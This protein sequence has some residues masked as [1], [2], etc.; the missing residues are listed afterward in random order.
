M[1]GK[2]RPR[3]RVAVVDRA[4]DLLERCQRASVDAPWGPELLPCTS[5][6]EVMGGARQDSLDGV[7]VR[8]PDAGP[9]LADLLRWADQ[10]LEPVLLYVEGGLEQAPE[11][12]RLALS[13]PFVRWRADA[14]ARLDGWL[15]DVA[16]LEATNRYRRLHEATAAELRGARMQLYHG[17]AEAAEPVAGPPCGPPL[18]TALAEVVPLKAAKMRFEQC[19]IRAAAR[20]CGSL[21]AAAEALGVS[22]SSLWRR[23]RDRDA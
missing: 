9:L 16:E 23:M 4:G 14:A 18:P 11:L 10:R 20:E 12:R 6:L 21:K 8:T 17:M 5:V 3:A 19:Q 13:R 7:A 1:S 15:S 2:I 22:Y